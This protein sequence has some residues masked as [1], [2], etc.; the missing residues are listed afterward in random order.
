MNK[1]ISEAEPP[2]IG[3]I[4]IDIR[5]HGTRLTQASKIRL[6]KKDDEPIAPIPAGRLAHVT[7]RLIKSRVTFKEVYALATGQEVRGVTCQTLGIRRE[8]LRAVLI[9]QEVNA[10]WGT[11]VPDYTNRALDHVF[12]LTRKRLASMTQK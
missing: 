8:D 3:K 10:R 7:A 9:L 5:V 11:R 2:S 4:Y 1:P 12:S 6:G